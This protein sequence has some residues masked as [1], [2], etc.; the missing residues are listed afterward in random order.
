M[1]K[2]LLTGGGTAGH[3][4][5]HLA[6]IPYLKK[7]NYHIDYMGSYNGIEKILIKKEGIPYYG[8]AS[9]KLRRYFDLKNF[10]DPFRVIF[11]T[12]QAI[13]HIHK[14]KPNVVFSKG[15]FISVPVVIGAWFNRVP[16]VIHESDMTPGLANKIA[17]KFA[18]K[19]CTTFDSTLKYV[20]TSKGIHTGSPI[21]MSVL[22]GDKNKGLNYTKLP[23]DKPILMITGGSL[24]SVAINICLRACLDTLTKTF[25]I[26]HQCGKDRI[27]TAYNHINGYRQYEFIG[28][29]MADIY[30]A[31][32]IIVA[33]A[34]SNT[35][36]EILALKKPN[37]LIPLPANQSRGD[38]L[39]NASAYEKSGYSMVLAQEHMNPATFIEAI[40][41]LYEHRNSFIS[42]MEQST[43][44]NGTLKILDVIETVLK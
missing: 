31:A 16:I 27:D 5:P 2:I 19:I 22:T 38:Q 28:T 7:N 24:G 42:N 10:T 26:I 41:K 35:I 13:H 6:L 33:R 4:M 8:I 20:P 39:L 37:L 21:R 34:G 3:V 14:L 18:Q 44:G 15:G 23:D 29:E 40:M 17:L 43:E 11:G 30:A 1:K 12:F 36:T 32:D 9:G 25:N